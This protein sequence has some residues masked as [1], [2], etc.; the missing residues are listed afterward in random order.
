MALKQKNAS[1]P[2]T[3][4]HVN[5]TSV[6]RGGGWGMSAKEQTPPLTEG[7]KT[8]KRYIVKV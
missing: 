6:G 3:I 7:L 1:K 4:S 8:I 2:E 5:Q